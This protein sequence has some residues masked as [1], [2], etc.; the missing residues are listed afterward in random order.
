MVLLAQFPNKE[1]LKQFNLYVYQ[2]PVV[3]VLATH[4]DQLSSQDQ[5]LI[6]IKSFHETN[7][8]SNFDSK[9]VERRPVNII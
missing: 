8:I 1:P 3:Q 2:Q 9:N 4:M 5:I 7:Q 6:K